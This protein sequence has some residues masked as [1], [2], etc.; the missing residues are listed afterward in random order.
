MWMPS[1]VTLLL[2]APSGATDLDALVPSV[3]ATVSGL[4]G[5]DGDDEARAVA[6]DSAGATLVAGWLDGLAG[7]GDDAFLGKWLPGQPAADWV[8]AVDGGPVDGLT[9]VVSDDRFHGVA[10][11]AADEVIVAGELSGSVLEG[12]ISAWHVR[13]LDATGS[14][15]L[16]AAT[17]QDSTASL[18]QAAHAVTVDPYGGDVVSVGWAFRSASI[19][20]RWLM[21][22]YLGTTGLVQA[23][24]VGLDVGKEAWAPDQAWGVAADGAGGVYVVGATGVDGSTGASNRNY[25]WV[26]RKYDATLGTV[27]WERTWAGLTGH[28]DI[29]RAVGVDP[30]GNVIVAGSTNAGSDNDARADRDWL[31][32]KYDGATGDVLWDVVWDSAGMGHDEEAFAVAVDEV[33]DVLVGGAAF[34]A[35]GA[36]SWR[37]AHLSGYD[38]AEL[39]ALTWSTEGEL[40]AVA[41]RDGQVALAGWELGADRDLVVRVFD[42]DDD[43]DG[44]GNFSDGCPTDPAKTEPEVCGCNASEVDVDGDGTEDCIDACPDLAEKWTDS[45]VCGCDEPDEDRDGDG[46]ED[47][48]DNCPDDPNK[49]ALGVCGCGLPDN[50]SDG[51]GVLGCD[52]ACSNTPPGTPVDENGCPLDGTNGGSDDTGISGGGETAEDGKGGCGCTSAPSPVSWGLALLGLAWRPRRRGPRR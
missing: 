3:D 29:A 25:D 47:C 2:V 30:D 5:Q 26:V 51:D 44:V 17:Y 15:V 10:V 34:D 40:R 23:G 41:L 36:R 39:G 8:V 22:R 18:V 45:G 14:N 27:S 28:D 4:A 37:L 21:Y 31:V 6:L 1:L 9:R 50:D 52:D 13:K 33:G 11:D 19:L 42:S 48:I 38:G 49:T 20:G 35:G 32:I 24:P 7:H 16:W 46:T 43:G 12:W